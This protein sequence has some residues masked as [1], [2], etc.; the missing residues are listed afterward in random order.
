MSLQCLPRVLWDAELGAPSDGVPQLQGPGLH[1]GFIV[2]SYCLCQ[3]WYATDLIHD[4]SPHGILCPVADGASV[5]LSLPPGG[6]TRV[7]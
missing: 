2:H 1:A 5:S 7:R 6:A 3:S 4:E